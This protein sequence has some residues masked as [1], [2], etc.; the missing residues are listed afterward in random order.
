MAGAVLLY[1][2]AP[3]WEVWDDHFANLHSLIMLTAYCACFRAHIVKVLYTMLL[4]FSFATFVNFTTIM[5]VTLISPGAALAITTSYFT[6]IIPVLLAL[7]LPFA[8]K[9]FKNTL[10]DAFNELTNKNIFYLCVTPALFYVL[11]FAYALTVLRLD[12]IPPTGTAVMRIL[13]MLVGITSFYINVRMVLGITKRIRAEKELAA[14]KAALE[15]HNRMKTEFLQ[16][17]KHEVRNPLHVISLGTDFVN[18]CIEMKDMDA[19]ARN[20]L[21]TIQNEALRLGRM[22]NGMVELANMSGSP[23]S[24]KRID[25]A[26]ILSHAA[27]TARL[28]AEK[29]YNAL[30]V[31][32]SPGLPYV[33]GEAEQLERVPVNL[34]ENANICTRNG[35]IAIEAKHSGEY[36]TV[37]VSD[38]GEGIDPDLLPRVFMRGVS[39]RGGKGY[40]LSMCR[41]IIEAHGGEIDIE[42]EIGKG[43]TVTFTIPVYGGQEN[44]ERRAA[45]NE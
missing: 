31:D 41:T 21:S 23:A 2:Y 43:T 45:N 6:M 7:V 25:F 36:I 1:A 11:L 16:D 4:V 3:D 10:R 40:G 19:E 39:G 18:Q 27:E 42:S 12:G 14:E 34:L 13:I 9:F 29:K 30:R 44:R 15:K 24:R 37:S 28:S 35:T 33:Y 20:A 38:T 8:Y 32:I 5:A 22:V 26:E 17:I